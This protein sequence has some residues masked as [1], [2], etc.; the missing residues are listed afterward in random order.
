VPAFVDKGA[1]S[2]ILFGRRQRQRMLGRHRHVG[3]AQQGV[4]ARGEH[5][6]RVRRISLDVESDLHTARLADP[7][8][9]HRAHGVGP[10]GQPVEIGEQFL[11]IGSGAQEPLRDLAALDRRIRTPA[12]A[13]D[14]LL[15]GQHGLVDRIPVDHRVGAVDEPLFQ[16]AREQPLFPAVIG[17]IAGSDL[18]RPVVGEAQALQLA[19]HVVDVL[20]R[21]RPG[22]H[23][24][25]HGRVLG[26]QAEGVPAHRLEHVIA[27]HAL[28]ARDHVADGVVAH[29]AHV[30]PPAGVGKH[31][32]AIELG[33]RRVLGHAV[34]ARGLPFGMGSPFNGMRVV[35]GFHR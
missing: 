17:R 8:A 7:V 20:A 13:V 27:L 15:V 6:E 5:L 3:R 21:P 1:D 29:M 4:G 32:Q 24:I 9:L 10:A 19:A 11:G 16:Q 35:D 2:R 14:D 12:P 33:A 23:A 28:E 25:L 30:E 22:R 34:A 26:R 18:A 31:R